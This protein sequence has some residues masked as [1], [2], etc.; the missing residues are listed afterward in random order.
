M[1]LVEA[2][3]FFS[4]GVYAGFS[5]RDADDA[6]TGVSEGEGR[7]FPDA[8]ACASDEGGFSTETSCMPAWID[9]GVGGVAVR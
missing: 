7:F 5:P 4:Y 2:V 8:A 9:E 1:L 3:D 6:C